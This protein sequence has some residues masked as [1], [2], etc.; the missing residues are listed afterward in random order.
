MQITRELL[1]FTG[2]GEPATIIRIETRS[3]D[4]NIYLHFVDDKDERFTLKL[5][6]DGASKFADLL[7][8]AKM[9]R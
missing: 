5:P 7:N 4:N 8:N 9:D 6:K 3:Y 1:L 2:V